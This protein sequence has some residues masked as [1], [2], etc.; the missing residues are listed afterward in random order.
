MGNVT[1]LIKP[2][3]SLCD[4][5]CR[6]CFYADEAAYRALPDMG[7]MSAETA[8]AVI[9]SALEAAGRSG[10]INFTFQGGEPTLAGLEFFRC[11]V[12]RTEAL[13]RRRVP[14]NWS[15][16]TNG[17]GLDRAWAEFFARRRFL[18]GV[19]LDGDKA[20]HDEN[21]VDAAGAGTWE[22]VRKNV[23]LLREHGAAVNLLCVVTGRCAKNAPRVY[24]ALRDTGV[25]HLQFI[26][27]LDPLGER[28]GQRDWSLTPERYG[29]FLCQ[30]FDRWYQ[31]W[32][33]GDYVSI[34][35][36]EDY[37]HLAMGLPP[38]TCAA[39]GGCGSYFVVEADGSAYPCDFYALDEWRMGR[40]GERS[41]EELARSEPAARFL[42]ESGCRPAQCAACPWERLCHGGCRRDWDFGR[43]GAAENYYCP[44][45]RRFF[46]YAAP[47]LREIARAEHRARQGLSG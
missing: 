24:R 1:M 23:D 3:S 28:R 15:V 31:D 38:S 14:V 12:E 26:P 20:L 47:R 41:L 32:K 44:A 18:V 6:Y 45:F 9:C 10:R 35:L 11:F 43:D 30:L 37:V 22:R 46:S 8:E 4:M 33:R 13:N 34:R 36:F 29:A 39:G 2:A 16:Q 25:R 7:V 27:C 17:L 42:T 19:S 21:R 5:R 40:V